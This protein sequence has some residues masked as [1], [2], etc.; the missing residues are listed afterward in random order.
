MELVPRGYTAKGLELIAKA[1]FSVDMVRNLLDFAQA[2][3]EDQT[4]TVEIRQWGV[5]VRV[6]AG[7]PAFIG[8]MDIM[9][10][11]N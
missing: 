5:W 4:V 1:E 2:V 7:P 10:D 3:G 11:K 8:S 6:P 9:T